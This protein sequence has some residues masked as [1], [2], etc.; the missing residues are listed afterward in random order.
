MPEN[1]LAM[2][3]R[4]RNHAKTT[5]ANLRGEVDKVGKSATRMGTKFGK[6]VKASK[7]SVSGLLGSMVSLKAIIIAAFAYKI[8]VRFARALGIVSQKA[9]EGQI[10]IVKLQQGMSTY[11]DYTRQGESNLLSLSNAM[12]QHTGVADDVSQTMMGLLGTYHMEEA[13][14]TRLTPLIIDFAKAKGVDL[15]TAFDLVG[16]ANVGYTGTLSRYGIILDSTLSKTEKMIA[17][18]EHLGKY[19][20]TAAA[21]TATY[22]G[23]TELLA[24]NHGDLQEAMGNTLQAGIVQ[25]GLL[26][27]LNSLVLKA[28]D[29]WNK[30]G[31][32]MGDIGGNK[33]TGVNAGLKGIQS[34]IA[35]DNTIKWAVTFYNITAGIYHGAGALFHRI[36]TGVKQ[37]S[38]LLEGGIIVAMKFWS[39]ITMNKGG[40][41]KW[42]AALTEWKK[43][44]WDQVDKIN[45]EGT[46]KWEN[47]TAMGKKNFS[48]VG[49]IWETGGVAKWKAA[50]EERRKALQ[51]VADAEAEAARRGV[52]NGAKHNDVLS[53][54]IQLTKTMAQQFA[55]AS[56]LEQAQTKY[57]MEKATNMSPD[58]VGGLSEQ[59]RAL[60]SKQG[61][62]KKGYEGVFSE[63]AERELGIKSQDASLKAKLTIDLTEEAKKL[64][65]ASGDGDKNYRNVQFEKAG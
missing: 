5:A 16:K 15:K 35:G 30:W 11:G 21:L 1:V 52:V 56:R 40:K 4:M 62:L 44:Y 48:N 29:F 43:G 27:T 47:S 17:L 58:E 53:R 24:A 31:V 32:V 59:E 49:D 63:Y 42:G 20:G 28:T 25:A 3:L 38:L 60:I 39:A 51:A 34:T 45:Q 55:S 22:A 9:K 23:K 61:V 41:E 7:S 6:G 33:L 14:I 12:Q 8:V 19:R 36:N 57:L 13:Q 2:T 18:E 50:M 37:M 46:K 26:T 65:T 64:L 10:A 54:T